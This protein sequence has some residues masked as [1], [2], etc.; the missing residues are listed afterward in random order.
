MKKVILFATILSAV[1]FT[2][3]VKERDCTCTSTYTPAGGSAIST[4][5]VYTYKDVTKRQAKNNCISM[6]YTDA[7]AGVHTEDC[8]LN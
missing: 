4:T 5:Q 6:T 1:S 8:K 3:C 2:S 7:A